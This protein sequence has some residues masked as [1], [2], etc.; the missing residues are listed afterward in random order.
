VGTRST[1]CRC[2]GEESTH[3]KCMSR[4]VSYSLANDTMDSHTNTILETTDTNAKNYIYVYVR[5]FRICR[6]CILNIYAYT[7]T[8]TTSR[9]PHDPSN[10]FF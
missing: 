8:T 7:H 4:T 2:S 10:F 1:R 3:C 6:I 9:V 5:I